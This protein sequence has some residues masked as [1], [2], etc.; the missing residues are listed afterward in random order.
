MGVVGWTVG[1]DAAD[2]VGV[3]GVET[4]CTHSLPDKVEVSVMGLEISNGLIGLD[5]V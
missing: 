4:G 1:V 5:S 2:D 3:V